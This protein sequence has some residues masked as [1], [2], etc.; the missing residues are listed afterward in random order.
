MNKTY[1]LALALTLSP[2]AVF[3]QD[4]QQPQEPQ[5]QEQRMPERKSSFEQAD[6]LRGKFGL[7]DKQFSKVYDAYTKYNKA[8]FGGE[9]FSSSSSRGSMGGPQGRPQGG[10]GGGG[11]MGGGPGGGG[12][13]GPGG[14]G[15]GP[16]GGMGGGPQGGPRGEQGMAPQGGQDAP[17]QLSEKD[18]EKRMKNMAKQEEKLAK[19]M[20][21][22]LVTDELYNEWLEY[23]ESQRPHKPEDFHRPNQQ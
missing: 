12:M 22:V 9:P 11:P 2:V 23:H 17:K 1:L 14:M 16:Q 10:P 8:V 21:K 13:G 20:K 19:S 5:G 6:Y 18:I 3:A 4:A 15:G 7:T